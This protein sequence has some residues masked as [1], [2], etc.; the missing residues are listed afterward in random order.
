MVDEKDILKRMDRRVQE[1]HEEQFYSGKKKRELNNFAYGILLALGVSLLIDGAFLVISGYLKIQENNEI[2]KLVNSTAINLTDSQISMISINS[3]YVALN[4]IYIFLFALGGLFLVYI[5]LLGYLGSNQDLLENRHHYPWQIRKNT[6]LENLAK[7][8]ENKI[9]DFMKGKNTG[10]K[11][12]FRNDRIEVVEFHKWKR[13]LFEKANRII[14]REDYVSILYSTSKRGER[15]GKIARE[16]I[17][18]SLEKSKL[19]KID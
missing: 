14:L 18:P 13:F 5:S 7:K 19:F 10:T 3:G 2:L 11:I 17:L 15:F 8:M 6:S 16:K 12:F 1:M 9:K 4:S